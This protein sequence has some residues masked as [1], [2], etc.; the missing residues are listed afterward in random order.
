MSF[1]EQMSISLCVFKVGVTSN[2]VVRYV[3]YKRKNFTAMWVIFC[4]SNAREIHMLEAALVSLFHSCSGCHNTP[5]SGGEG[6]LNRAF[7][8]PPYYA[9]VAGGRA[10]QNCRVG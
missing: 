3:D 5:G 7:S 9:Y 6:A 10:D 2:P 1:R 8:K 4:G